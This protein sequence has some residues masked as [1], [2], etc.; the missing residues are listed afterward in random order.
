M[1]TGL[2]EGEEH[3]GTA[4]TAKFHNK[5]ERT[6]PRIEGFFLWFSA[7]FVLQMQPTPGRFEYFLPNQ[8][9][10]RICM[11]EETTMNSDIET[12]QTSDAFL[13]GWDD[14]V[15]DEPADQTETEET[16]KQETETE[17]ETNPNDQQNEQQA[18]EGNPG[19]EPSET[20]AE[21]NPAP[22]Q[23]EKKWTLHHLQESREV[24]E[25]ELVALAQQGLDYERIR[26]KYD[27]SKPVMELF[28][29]FAKQAD[30]SITDYLAYIRTEAKRASGM[31]DAEAK[32]A[33]D[34]EDR[35]A[36]VAAKEAAEQEKNAAKESQEAAEARRKADIEK[37]QKTYPDA[38]KDPQSIPKE[39]WD[40]VKNGLSLVESYA[41]WKQKAAETALTEAKQQ[42]AAAVQNQKNASRS[43]GS[44][45]S[46]GESRKSK[47]P[48][49][50]GWD[51]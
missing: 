14:G 42:Q 6:A 12:E 10:K 22:A 8:A 13:E 46:A 26:S 3:Q 19:N 39:V 27:E 48:F 4:Y 16:A 45:K 44:M 23:E 43:T 28:R 51:S 29:Q 37:F 34:L 15:S 1:H 31:S 21:Q 2:P 9:G 11:N 32:R 33:I 47:D 35:E 41:V 5:Q 50:E 30:M 24:N 7:L 38:A 17:H 49:L 25:S 36:A 18:T 20:P 40:G